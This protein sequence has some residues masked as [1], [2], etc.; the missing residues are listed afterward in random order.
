[1][2][3]KSKKYKLV[4]VILLVSIVLVAFSGSVLQAQE[5]SPN[6]A[7]T[8][9]LKVLSESMAASDI[10]EI[11]RLIE[12]GADVNVINKKGVTPLFQAS[13]EGHYEIVK[14]L[15]DAKADV[16]KA[17]TTNGIT[18]LFWASGEGHYEVVKLLLD[19]K[20]DVNIKVEIEGKEYT[21][22]SAAKEGGHT[23]IVKLL[24]EYGAKE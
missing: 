23:S 16:N 2:S 24:K 4:W 14:L 5:Q 12:A 1:M 18:P 17:R 10:T 21:V 6:S 11:R 19:A 13:V 3:L 9:K 22:L 20:A 7:A 15:L 8:A